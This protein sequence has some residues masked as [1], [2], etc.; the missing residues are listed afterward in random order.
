[1]KDETYKFRLKYDFYHLGECWKEI[2]KKIRT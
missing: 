1:M 2:V